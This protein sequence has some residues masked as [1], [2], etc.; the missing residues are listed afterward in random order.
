VLHV[1]A[2]ADRRGHTPDALV[3]LLVGEGVAV[4]PAP[5]ILATYDTERR[6]HALPW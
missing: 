5:K 3:A 1:C 4:A 2:Q 6:D